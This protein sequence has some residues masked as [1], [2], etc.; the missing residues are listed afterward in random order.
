MGLA[1]GELGGAW[2]GVN[3][4]NKQEISAKLFNR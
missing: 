3:V 1:E 2:G 4:I